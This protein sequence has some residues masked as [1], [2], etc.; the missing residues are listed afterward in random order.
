MPGANWGMAVKVDRAEGPRSV[1]AEGS[2]FPAPEYC[3]PHCGEDS[4]RS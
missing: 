4:W 2:V 1:M 3:L